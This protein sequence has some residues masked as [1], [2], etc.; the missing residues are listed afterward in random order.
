MVWYRLV[1]FANVD[2]DTVGSAVMGVYGVINAELPN[3]AVDLEQRIMA[4]RIE[5]SY[6]GDYHRC[7]SVNEY[8]FESVRPDIKLT[9][10]SFFLRHFRSWL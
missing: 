1:P 8:L 3:P 7:T 4:I 6:S 10:R 5:N 2:G 9:G